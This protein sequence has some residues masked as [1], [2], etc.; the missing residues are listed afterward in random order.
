MRWGAIDIGT[1]SCRLLIA[2]VNANNEL[3]PL[4]ADMETTRIGEGLNQSASLKEEAIVR[5][6]ICLIGFRKRLQEFHVKDYRVIATS[7]VRDASN[8]LEFTARV[9]KESGLAVEVISGATE[10]RL[11]YA[12][13]MRG[14]ELIEAPLVVDLGGGSTEFICPEETVLLSVPLGAVR[15][16]E[17]DIYA[18]DI[19]EVLR[20]VVAL[21]AQLS[22]HPLV[23]VGGA[24]STLVA[25]KKGLITYSP[26]LVHGEC[27]SRSEIADLYDLLDSLPLELR[28]RL[29]GLQ[30]ERADIIT[31]GA[32][33]ILVIMEVLGKMEIVVSESDILQ[34]LIWSLVG[35][36]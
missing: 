31:K 2:E 32:L 9:L 23:M 26:E 1:N 7:A 6:I 18:A 11:S 35:T 19:M 36:D 22:R 34:G 8:R 20:P 33:I 13:V 30:P 5:T 28:R 17:G 16:A 25:V 29:P 14:L 12:G 15:A 10:A 3:T 4:Y 24:A 27:L 21:K